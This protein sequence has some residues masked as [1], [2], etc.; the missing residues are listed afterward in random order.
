MD[1]ISVGDNVGVLEGRGDPAVG[2][3][4]SGLWLGSGVVSLVVGV[5][6]WGETDGVYNGCVF[7]NKVFIAETTCIML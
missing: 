5:S 7:G 3:D 4:V 2:L 6:V 1:S